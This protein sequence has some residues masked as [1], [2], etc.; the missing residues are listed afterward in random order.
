MS[1]YPTQLSWCSNCPSVGQWEPL[2]S[3]SYVHMGFSPS[4]F[5]SLRTFFLLSGI[6]R[7][8]RIILYILC[9]GPEISRFFEEPRFFSAEKVYDPWRYTFSV[10]LSAVWVLGQFFGNFQL[11]GWW[12]LDQVEIMGCR[13][14]AVLICS[15]SVKNIYSECVWDE[16]CS[17]W[18]I[19][20]LW[21]ELAGQMVSLSFWLY[22]FGRGLACILMNVLLYPFTLPRLHFEFSCCLTKLCRLSFNIYHHAWKSRWSRWEE[23][24]PPPS[25]GAAC[26]CHWPPSVVDWILVWELLRVLW[27]GMSRIIIA[28]LWEHMVSFIQPTYP[29]RPTIPLMVSDISL[30]FGA[31]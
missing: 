24:L 5:I 3:G 12:I 6:M 4:F 30:L 15:C 7:C 23:A 28:G 29:H 8:S 21:L 19:C 9:P 26:G 11:L 17:I 13:R 20:K 22:L 1:H 14:R 16:D 27:Y 25:V 10:V 2:Q 31:I 18:F